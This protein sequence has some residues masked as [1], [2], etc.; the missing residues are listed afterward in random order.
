MA[1]LQSLV[2]HI[3]YENRREYTH[4]EGD[5]A[6]LD[7]SPLRRPFNMPKSQRVIAIIIIAI[8][9]CDPVPTHLT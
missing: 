1:D 4:V 2:D 8:K 9:F 5:V 3:H 6:Y 7:G